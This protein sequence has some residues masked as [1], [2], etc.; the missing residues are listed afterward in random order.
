MCAKLSSSVA[1]RRLAADLR[2]KPSENP[3]QTV[4]TYCHRRISKFLGEYGNC[5][6]VAELLDLSENKLETRIIEISSDTELRE[7]QSR[8]VS[9]GELMFATLDQE[10]G[11]SGD[12]GITIKL[13]NREPW[14]QRYV[15]IIDCRGQKHQRRY[16]TKWHEIAHL[17]ILTDQTRLEFH[18]SH[19]SGQLKSAEESLVDSIA[20]E[21]SF[22]PD[23][24]RPHLSGRISFQAIEEVRRALCP[25]ASMYSAVLNLSKLWPTPCVWLEARLA[26]KKSEETTQERFA[27]KEPPERTLRVIHTIANG[28]ARERGLSIIPRFRVPK[29]SVI[30]QVFEQGLS[31][32]EASED[33]AWW[34]SSDGTQLSPCRVR[35]QAKRIGENIHALVAPS[36]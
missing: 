9:R 10:L 36:I 8:Y 24:I 23:L 3:V 31:F 22:Y 30:N 6:T 25:E 17:L 20:G 4:L 11:R 2:L 18:R 27:F 29:S 12:F 15:S 14:E 26:A 32:G 28:P 5:A 13:T 33:L 35:V 34:E 7:L 21:M 16:H 1:V 19:D